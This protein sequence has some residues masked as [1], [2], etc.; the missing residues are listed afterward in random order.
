MIIAIVGESKT[1]KSSFCFTGPKRIMYCEL[2]MGGFDRAKVRFMPDVEKG[3]IVQKRYPLPQ[4]FIR[5]KLLNEMKG[6]VTIKQAQKLVGIKELWYQLLTDVVNALEG[7][8]FNTVVFDSFPQLRELCN[9]AYLQERQENQF[10]SNGQ[11]KPGENLRMTLQ[12]EEYGEPNARLLALLY[13]F[14]ETKKHLFLPIYME[15]RYVKKLVGTE[16][17]D[18]VEGRKYAGWDGERLHKEIDIVLHSYIENLNGSGPKPCARITV[19]G[20]GLGLVGMPLVEP[21]Y[22]KLVGLISMV[23]GVAI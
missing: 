7:D 21:S 14:R 3:L 10:N 18:V 23:N 22:D 2:D 5:E 6:K 8:E 17:V 4:Q 1:G 15:D 16:L 12:R 9:K 20:L 11:L 13:S 19:S